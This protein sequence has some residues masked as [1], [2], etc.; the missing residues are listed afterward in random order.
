MGRKTDRK[1]A[2]RKETLRNLAGDQ[3][4][5]VAGGILRRTAACDSGTCETTNTCPT[6]KMCASLGCETNFC[7]P[8]D[9]CP[10]L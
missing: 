5:G 2:L 8:T 4:G 9:G 6:E 3:L 7:P 1:L 10:K